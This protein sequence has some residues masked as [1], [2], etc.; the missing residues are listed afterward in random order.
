MSRKEY[1]TREAAKLIG[2]SRQTL[3]AWCK[4]GFIDP[5]PLECNGRVYARLWSKAH[6]QRAKRFKGTLRRGPE[7][8]KAAK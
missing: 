2:V 5:Y 3:Q 6:I 4:N 1:T 7:P 8:K